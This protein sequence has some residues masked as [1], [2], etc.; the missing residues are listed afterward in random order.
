MGVSRA[1][2]MDDAFQQPPGIIL[3]DS[4]KTNSLNRRVTYAK[5]ETSTKKPTSHA[6]GR[7]NSGVP[8]IVP[9]KPQEPSSEESE[10]SEDS[11][12]SGG[13]EG[14]G[15]EGSEDEG[16]EGSE[17]EESE[18]SEDQEKRP[19]LAFTN[20]DNT[21]VTRLDDDQEGPSNIVDIAQDSDAS[22]DDDKSLRSTNFSNPN[23]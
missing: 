13:S 15:S 4:S 5:P 11:E 8:T 3:N 16:S 23:L 12:E 17:D 14:S 9:K 19:N 21:G 1:E 22:S 7:P 6:N 20:G 2:V 10:E 18:D